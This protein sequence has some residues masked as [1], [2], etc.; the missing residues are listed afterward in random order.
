MRFKKTLSNDAEN[1]KKSV[2][3]QSPFCVRKGMIVV[4]YKLILS[5]NTARE[6][7]LYNI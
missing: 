6:H 2:F 3:L 1:E 4:L 7:E 5:N